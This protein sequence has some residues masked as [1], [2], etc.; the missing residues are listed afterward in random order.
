[1]GSEG[2]ETATT[3]AKG[4]AVSVPFRGLWGLKGMG[5]RGD[6]ARRCSFSPLPGFM[7]SEGGSGRNDAAG[8]GR[9]SVPFRGLWGLKGATI[10]ALYGALVAF[11]SP[12]GVYGV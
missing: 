4:L 11:Q 9:V 8:R 5:T 7:G 10:L 2:R 6:G 12:S 3:A 1:M